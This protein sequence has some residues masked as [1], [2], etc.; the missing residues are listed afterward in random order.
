MGLCER[1][2]CPVGRFLHHRID[3]YLFN[4][5]SATASQFSL[6]STLTWERQFEQTAINHLYLYLF[7]ATTG[8]TVA[9]SDSTV[10]NVQHLYVSTLAPGS[11]DLVVTKNGGTSSFKR[12]ECGE[13]V[14]ELRGGFQFHCRP[15]ARARTPRYPFRH[16]GSPLDGQ[17]DSPAARDADGKKKRIL[18]MGSAGR[19]T[20][21]ARLVGSGA[22]SW[23]AA[24]DASIWRCGRGNSQS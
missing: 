10:D 6:I 3:H 4:L 7:N 9:V 11:Y 16:F 13:F 1:Y 15:G 21:Q 2:H 5:S 14:R 12:R 8:A 20:C 18:K 22:V 23:E 17:G 19:E 24:P